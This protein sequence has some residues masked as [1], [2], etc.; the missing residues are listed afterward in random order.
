MVGQLAHPGSCTAGR[1]AVQKR[2][3]GKV[4]M[5][6]A[7]CVKRQLRWTQL[8]QDVELVSLRTRGA[9]KADIVLA[10]MNLSRRRR[11][12]EKSSVSNPRK[13]AGEGASSR[14]GLQ[15]PWHSQTR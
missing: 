5:G 4:R 1:E 6:D 9:R 11:K 7:P 10:A 2:A 13:P 3:A 14:G 12:Q 8:F 15:L